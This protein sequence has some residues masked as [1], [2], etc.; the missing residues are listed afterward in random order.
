MAARWVLTRS[1]EHAD[2]S[3]ATFD[4]HATWVAQ[5]DGRVLCTEAG[6]MRIGEGPG[7][8]ASQTYLWDVDLQVFFPDGRFFHQVPLGGGDVHHHC[9][10][11]QYDGHYSFHSLTAFSVLW[12]VTGPRKDYVMRSTY[13]QVSAE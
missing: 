5:N 13:R 10:P 11:D 2:G 3:T 6:E 7:M 8:S 12:R 4:G 9:A 1:I